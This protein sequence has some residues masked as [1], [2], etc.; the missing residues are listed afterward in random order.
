MLH[1]NTEFFYLIPYAINFTSLCLF[2]TITYADTL[3]ISV[4]NIEFIRLV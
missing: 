3:V 2:I 4:A 1:L